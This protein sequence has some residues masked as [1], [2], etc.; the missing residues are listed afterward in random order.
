MDFGL[1]KDPMGLL[2]SRGAGAQPAFSVTDKSHVQGGD[3]DSLAFPKS[4]ML[5][6]IDHS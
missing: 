3:L 5:V 4:N 6:K 1:K 2:H